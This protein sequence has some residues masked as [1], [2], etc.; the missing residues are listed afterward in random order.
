MYKGMPLSFMKDKMNIST[1]VEEQY[2]IRRIAAPRIR[3]AHPAVPLDQ[4]LFKLLISSATT[5]QYKQK[6]VQ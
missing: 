1:T 4:I 5:I 2:D 3:K 6:Q